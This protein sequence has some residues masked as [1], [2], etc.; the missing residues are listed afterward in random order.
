MAVADRSEG[1]SPGHGP[2]GQVRGTVP[3]DGR[4]GT[5]R[6][7]RGKKPAVGDT[8]LTMNRTGRHGGIQDVAGWR[9][10]QLLD[11]GFAPAAATRL[12]RDMRRDVHAL[13]ELVERGCPPE[14]AERIL[15]PLEDGDA[16]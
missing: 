6:P 13:I 16:R 11:A 2:R 4:R 5:S 8:K 9:R 14:L 10:R 12:A 7:P 15:A 3:R 1:L